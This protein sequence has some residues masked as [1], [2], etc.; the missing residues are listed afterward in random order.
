MA[1]L[2]RS[3]YDEAPIS[4]GRF[5]LYDGLSLTKLSPSTFE[6]VRPGH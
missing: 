6:R 5:G 2:I 3:V 1:E 4:Y